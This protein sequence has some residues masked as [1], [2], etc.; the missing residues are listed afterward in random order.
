MSIG[1]PKNPEDDPPHFPVMAKQKVEQDKTPDPAQDVAIQPRLSPI[2]PSSRSTLQARAN[3]E[4][5]WARQNRQEVFA[6]YAK[7]EESMDGR[8]I[9]GDLFVTLLPSVDQN[10]SLVH[11]LDLA[12]MNYLAVDLYDQAVSIER[13]NGASTVIIMVGAAGIGKSTRARDLFAKHPEHV[14]TIL[15]SNGANW[16]ALREAV[17]TATRSGRNVDIM[18]IGGDIAGSVSRTVSRCRTD[19]RVVPAGTQAFLHRAAP[20]NFLRAMAEISEIGVGFAAFDSIT[21]SFRDDPAGLAVSD[22]NDSNNNPA[23]ITSLLEAS[24]HA[25]QIAPEVRHAFLEI[26]EE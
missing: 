19:F 21:Q 7:L 12:D 23:G 15:D 22:L 4:M 8:V 6:A 5:A 3:E 10:P 1:G 26:Q 14:H 17:N 9:N 13:E 18:Y 20:A 16:I 25:Q 24:F 11:T 2:P